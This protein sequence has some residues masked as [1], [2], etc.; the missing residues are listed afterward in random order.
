MSF[1]RK[2]IP[3]ITLALAV[4]TFTLLFR[5]RTAAPTLNRIPQKRKENLSAEA[6]AYAAAKECAAENTAATE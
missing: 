4:G 5:R 3:A 1:K 2:L 6:T